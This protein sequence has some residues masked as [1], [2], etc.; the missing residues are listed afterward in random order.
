M[1]QAVGGIASQ[2]L[3]RKIRIVMISVLICGRW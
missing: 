3:L 2:E 1:I